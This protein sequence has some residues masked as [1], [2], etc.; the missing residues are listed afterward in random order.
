[1]IDYGRPKDLLSQLPGKGR[2]VE[3]YFTKTQENAVVRL[4]SIEGIDNAL[5]NKVG[6]NFSILTDLNT[7]TLVD[8]IEIEFGFN[9][10]EGVKQRD[11][12]M[13][14]YFRYKAMEVPKIEP[15]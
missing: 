5:E 15:F 13:E 8:R 3:L 4:E 7:R 1:M 10:I 2:T 14:E 9:V 12:R 6:T 11:S